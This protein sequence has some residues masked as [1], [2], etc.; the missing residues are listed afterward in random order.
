MWLESVPGIKDF[1]PVEME[2]GEFCIF[3]GNKCFHGNKDNDTGKTRVSFD[4]RVMPYS[5]YDESK[6]LE[7]VTINRKF[8]IGD[9]YDLYKNV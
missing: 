4:F 9:Y 3:N 7:S 5:R 1:H 2:V 6:C 8:A